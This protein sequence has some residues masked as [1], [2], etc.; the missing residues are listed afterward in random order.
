MFWHLLA[1]RRSS[2]GFTEAVDL[3]IRNCIAIPTVTQM[4]EHKGGPQTTPFLEYC[5]LTH[6]TVSP[7]LKALGFIPHAQC[8]VAFD[9]KVFGYESRPGH[10]QARNNCAV[11]LKLNTL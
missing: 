2:A 5:A 7:F 6:V 8:K 3:R 9:S 11:N 10:R 4:N 1:I